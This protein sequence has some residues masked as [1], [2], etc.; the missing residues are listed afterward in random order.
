MLYL[1]EE[2]GILAD[3]QPLVDPFESAPEPT[4]TQ[5][6]T[7]SYQSPATEMAETVNPEVSVAFFVLY[8]IHFDK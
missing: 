3:E 2:A 7:H 5:N 8:T 4:M 6:I 1:G